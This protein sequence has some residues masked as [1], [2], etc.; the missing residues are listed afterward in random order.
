MHYLQ[1]PPK[2]LLVCWSNTAKMNKPVV[3]YRPRCREGDIEAACG[4]ASIGGREMT[5]IEIICFKCGQ[6]TMIDPPKSKLKKTVKIELI[7][8]IC[9]HKNILAFAYNIKRKRNENIV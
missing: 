4:G 2:N 8:G 1:Q 5:E 6:T 9:G 7:C 3:H